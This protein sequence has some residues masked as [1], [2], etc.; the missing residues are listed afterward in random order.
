MN[1][2]MQVFVGSTFRVSG[3]NSLFVCMCTDTDICLK[4]IKL[5]AELSVRRQLVT[6]N[7]VVH[8]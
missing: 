7:H 2:F 6:E 1:S 3:H 5:V 8:V 4:C